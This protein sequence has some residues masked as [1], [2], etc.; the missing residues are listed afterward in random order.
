MMWVLAI[1]AVPATVLAQSTPDN[2]TLR[3]SPPV[4][5]GYGI[6]FVLLVAVL[7][8]SLMPSKRGHQD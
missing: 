3:Q 1:L 5:W 2:P 6:L 4:W 7:A 8:V